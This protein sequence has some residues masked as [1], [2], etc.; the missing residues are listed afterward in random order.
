MPIPT[1]AEKRVLAKIHAPPSLRLACQTRPH[2]DLAVQPLLNPSFVADAPLQ[3]RGPEFGEEREV[4]VLFVDVRHSTK[5]AESRLPYDV[6]FLLNYFFAEMAE[7]V[8]QAQGH[9]SNFTGDGL[10][11]IFGLRCQTKH[12]HDPR[13]FFAGDMLH[14]LDQINHRLAGELEEPIRIGI[15]IHTGVAIIGRMGP[16]KQPIISALGDTVN[17]AAR[18]E[19]LTKE[20]GTRS[21]PPLKRSPLPN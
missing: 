6:V 15:G 1:L 4:T 5:F 16:P 2:T 7:A 9:Y 14:R 17:I 12:A 18:V 20:I 10:M 11:A 21:S 3:Q 8:E 13:W 19:S